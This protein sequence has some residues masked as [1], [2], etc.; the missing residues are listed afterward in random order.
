MEAEF[1]DLDF[2]LRLPTIG[3][4]IETPT[5]GGETKQGGGEQEMNQHG[6]G[7]H[8][9]PHRFNVTRRSNISH[10]EN[11]RLVPADIVTQWKPNFLAIH[12]IEHPTALQ[13]EEKCITPCELY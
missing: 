3:A 2:G 12:S 5:D 10:V 8:A 9:L 4:D 1:H 13:R 7:K 6:E 11:W